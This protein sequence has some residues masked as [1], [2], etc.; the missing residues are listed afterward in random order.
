MNSGYEIDRPDRGGEEHRLAP[1]P[2]EAP[3][4]GVRQITPAIEADRNV[5]EANLVLSAAHTTEGRY[6]KT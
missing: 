2:M 5:D 1:H 6:M 3:V 4:T